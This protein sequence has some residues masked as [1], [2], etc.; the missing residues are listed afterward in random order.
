MVY[1]RYL[2]EFETDIV[3]D[4]RTSMG[5]RYTKEQKETI[6][7]HRFEHRRNKSQTV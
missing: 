6:L 4:Q 2:E 7:K 1:K 5:E 3:R